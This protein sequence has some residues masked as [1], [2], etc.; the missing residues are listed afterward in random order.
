MKPT[1]FFFLFNLCLFLS[2]NTF[3][4]KPQISVTIETGGKSMQPQDE[5]ET[6]N[7]LETPTSIQPSSQAVQNQLKSGSNGITLEGPFCNGCDDPQ[8]EKALACG[9][10]ENNII[11]GIDVSS[12]DGIFLVNSIDF[13]QESFGGA[14][15]VTVN[16][17]C[18]TAG[19]VMYTPADTPLYSETFT[20][21]SSDD[22]KCVTFELTTPPTINSDCGTTLWIEFKTFSGRVVATPETCNGKIGT[23]NDSYFRNPT[24]NYPIPVKFQTVNVTF[25]LDASFAINVTQLLA[26]EGDLEYCVSDENTILNAVGDWTEYLWSNGATTQT[27]EVTE[28]TYTVTATNNIE[29]LADEVT[30]IENANPIPNITGDLEYCASDLTTTLDAGTWTSYL[31]SNDDDTQSIEATAGTYTVTVTNNNGCTGTDQ[32]TVVENE[33]AN[34]SISGDLEYCNGENTTLDAGTWTSYLWSN[35]NDNQSIE[36]TAGTYTVTVTNSNGCTGTDQVTVIENDNPTPNITGILE[37]CASNNTTTLDA[38][39]WSTYSWSNEEDTQTI[40]ATAGTYT[41]TVSDDNGCTGTDQ[42]SVVENANPTPN[43]HAPDFQEIQKI[44]ASD[45]QTDDR[46]GGSVAI[47]ENYAIVGAAGEDTGGFDAGAA[48]IFEKDPSSN[49]WVFVKKIQASDKAG[50]DYF[51]TSVSISGNHAVIGAFGEDTGGNNAG[52]AY[53]FEKDLGG[54]D[55]WGEVKKIQ[56]SDKTTL[57]QFGISVSI[58]GNHVIVGAHLEDTGGTDAGAAYIFA[59]DQGGTDNWGQVKKIQASDKVSGDRFGTSVS[60]SGNHAIIGAFAEDTGGTAY[61]FEKDQGGVNNWGEAKKLQASDREEDD[62][63]GFSVS[64]LGTYAIVGARSEVTDG[65]RAGAAYIFEKDQGGVNNWGEVKKILASDKQTGDRFGSSV[66]ISGDYVIVGAQHQAGYIGAAYI[67]GKDQNGTN[68]WGEVKKIQ[69]SDKNAGDRFGSSVA[70]S[71]N[72]AIVGTLRQASN[73]GAAYVFQ[74]DFSYCATDGD[75]VLDAGVWSGYQ[76]SND[77]T[78]QIIAA[79]AGTYTV[80]VTGDNGCTGTDQVSVVENANP[81]PNISGDLDY[82]N[83]GNTTLDAGTW[84]SYQWSNNATTQAVEVTAG[85]YAVTVTN[86][87]GCTGTDEVKVVENENANPSISGD[88]EYCNG[89]NTTLDAG[90]WTS[91]LWSNNE[92]TQTIEATAGTYT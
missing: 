90:S 59:K 45:K 82:C 28:G 81:V 16:L 69:A 4:Q 78:T 1:T 8:G 77:A 10:G 56:A 44:L 5:K 3:A 50:P 55:N 86:S 47:S 38:G 24:C 76:W 37:Y 22:G 14:P 73:T 80:T 92:D 49:N 20:T 91:Y 84:A 85:T 66:A 26:I 17:F 34:P 87:N 53:I 11:Q 48:Y 63:F 7:S 40:E 46:F 6:T 83:G 39:T 27:I 35:D 30:V 71:G 70:I 13:N 9:A 75:I 15:N 64:I 89:G 67:F 31:W 43:I 79:T 61:I 60:I 62:E 58:S 41:V 33:N 18:G 54:T 32:V 65:D 36:A 57:D 23:G 51:G 2:M 29:S 74:G 52:A 12:I 21:Q 19:T 88:L 68:N 42:V 72:D 25:K